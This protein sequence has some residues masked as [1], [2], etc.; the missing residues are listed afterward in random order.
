MSNPHK[1]IDWQGGRHTPI[2]GRGLSLNLLS[3]KF[4]EN[5]KVTHY[6]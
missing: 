6:A 3:G 2:R 4:Y 1:I 5:I